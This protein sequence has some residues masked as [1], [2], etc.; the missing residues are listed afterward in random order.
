MCLS[1]GQLSKCIKCAPRYDHIK[2]LQCTKTTV[3]LL[4][5]PRG[6]VRRLFM[7]LIQVHM[8]MDST[9]YLLY[10]NNFEIE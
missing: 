4:G 8:C 3:M 6:T 2:E 5:T 7:F 10:E 9:L 1:W